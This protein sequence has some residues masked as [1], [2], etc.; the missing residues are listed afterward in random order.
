MIPDYTPWIVS[1]NMYRVRMLSTSLIIA[2]I[3]AS[4]VNRCEMPSWNV[5]NKTKTIT[6][7]MMLKII[8]R[9]EYFFAKL[10]LP[11]PRKTPAKAEAA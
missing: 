10:I 4:F 9:R 5:Y 6:V 1:K 2:T 7:T 11:R 3:F 8:V